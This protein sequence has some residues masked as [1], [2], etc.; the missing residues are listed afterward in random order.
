MG[1]QSLNELVADATGEEVKL[2]DAIGFVP[3]TAIPVEREPQI[4]D[5][6]ARDAERL[7][8][9]PANHGRPLAN[10]KGEAYV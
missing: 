4:V 10:R 8:L 7:S 2:I 1:Q 6:D 5:W 3:L 9:F